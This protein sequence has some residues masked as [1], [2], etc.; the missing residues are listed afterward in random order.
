MEL[1]ERE[2]K[3]GAA[4]ARATA[5]AQEHER[6]NVSC[7]AKEA[8][9][10]ER[11]KAAGQASAAAEAT[12]LAAGQ[13]E[14]NAGSARRRWRRA[15]RSLEATML[16]TEEA[17]REVSRNLDLA[18]SALGSLSQAEEALD[19]R[20]QRLNQSWRTLQSEIISLIQGSAEGA[21][22]GG[23]MPT[24]AR[25]AAEAHEAAAAAAAFTIRIPHAVQGEAAETS[26][27]SRIGHLRG[28]LSRRE[29]ALQGWA[30]SLSKAGAVLVAERKTLN[31]ARAA[32]AELRAAAET[33][34]A[35]ASERLLA[36]EEQVATMERERKQLEHDLTAL[37][38]AR[39]EFEDERVA[40]ATAKKAGK[41]LMAA[42]EALEMDV[43]KRIRELEPKEHSLNMREM[44]VRE[45]EDRADAIVADAK[46]TLAD[47]NAEAENRLRADRDA[48]ARANADANAASERLALA[49]TPAAAV[50]SAAEPSRLRRRFARRPDP[51]R[52]RRRSSPWTTPRSSAGQISTRARRAYA[53]SREGGARARHHGDSRGAAVSALVGRQPRRRRFAFQSRERTRVPRWVNPP[54][55]PRGRVPPPPGPVGRPPGA[56][57][58]SA[59]APEPPQ[60]RRVSEESSARR[61]SEAGQGGGGTEDGRA[62]R[63]ASEAAAIKAKAEA[64]ARAAKAGSS[65]ISGP[66]WTRRDERRRRRRAYGTPSGRG[67]S[68]TVPNAPRRE[69]RRWP[70]LSAPRRSP[71]ARSSR[72]FGGI[73]SA[74]GSARR[75]GFA[76]ASS[77]FERR[78]MRWRHDARRSRRRRRW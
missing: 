34:H 33:S 37:D 38:L 25:V 66:R 5:L 69:P 73:P 64:D 29:T 22:S 27:A 31:E 21:A 24:E 4:I 7:G 36:V 2:D 40:A 52:R 11:E 78:L 12:L 14:R 55:A 26:F 71:N 16:A 18:R 70:P 57:A 23:E 3:A 6:R 1:R 62:E 59:G 44:K 75:S 28:G 49:L 35:Q 53:G 39:K 30:L 8:A 77:G 60:R 45:A 13:W 19:E 32:A 51:R 67:C 50:A 47:A 17:G 20:E 48:R 46:R 65:G 74:S 43:R 9:A 58:R 63:L 72:R 61:R 10:D 56:D 15:G 41:E 54:R 68:E 42:S 76:T